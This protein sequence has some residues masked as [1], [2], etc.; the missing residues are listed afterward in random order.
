MDHGGTVDKT[1]MM[2]LLRENQGKLCRVVPAL[3]HLDFN[4]SVC[5]E[6]LFNRFDVDGDGELD[7]KEF[8]DGFVLEV[9]LSMGRPR[10][11]GA[12]RGQVECERDGRA[13]SPSP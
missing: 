4:S 7:K 1:E 9:C 2:C 11:A 12:P 10:G 5:S 8:V 13:A 3:K 6:G